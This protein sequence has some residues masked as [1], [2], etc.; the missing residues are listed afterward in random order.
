MAPSS[1]DVFHPI[2]RQWFEES[3]AAP[4]N[5][6]AR[7]W[8]RIAA[9]EH[10]LVTAPT[11]SGK[12]LTAFLWAI[13]RLLTGVWPGGCVRVLYVSPLRA[14]N[15]DI[16]R[17]LGRPLEELVERFGAAGVEVPKI[18]AMT[19]SGDTSPAERRRMLKSP[20][21]ILI[22]T[23]ESLN[24]L[25]TS[26][27]GRR[28][29][30]GIETVILDEV[31]AVAATKRGT[32]LITAVDRL[33]L[34]SGEFQRLAL[35]AT[36]RPLETIGEWIGGY[37][38]RQ[39]AGEP[40]DDAVYRKRSVRL[41]R[42]ADEKR[43][44]VRVCSTV[45]GE[46]GDD[47]ANPAPW[48]RMTEAFRKIVRTN[49]STLF[50]ANSRRLTEKVTRL[51]NEGEPAELAYSHHGS[52]SREV[53]AVVERRLKDGELQAIVATSSLE[54]G[55]DV[56]SLDEVVLIQTPRAISAAVQ[57][58]GRA[59]HGVGETSRAR[60][61]PTH[62]R[63]FL[64]AAVVARSIHAGE[65]EA[66]RP[67]TGALD[68]LAQVILSMTA[69]ETWQIDRLFDQL[70]TSV[71]YHRLSRRQFELVLEMLAGRYAD[72][73]IRELRPRLMVDRVEGTVKARRGTARLVYLAGGTIADR[74]YYALRLEESLAKIGE[75]DEEFVFERS[76]GD[77]FT[78]GAQNW[79]I[80]RITHNDVL[81]VPARR[82]SA[83]APFWRADALDR[84]AFFSEKIA[85]LLGFADERLGEDVLTETLS[86]Q[87]RLEPAAAAE[88]V[89]FLAR[90][91][92][93]T[94]FLPHRRR[95]LVERVTRP[96]ER[97]DREQLI[98]HTVWGGR[99]NRPLAI[100]LAGAWEERYGERLEIVHDDDCLLLLLPRAVAGMAAEEIFE[101]V[102]PDEIEELLRRRLEATGFFG[103]R[104]RV[105]A[106]TALLLPRSGFRHRTPLWLNRQRSKKLIE[107]VARYGDFP[108]LVETWR[109]CLE[110][111]LDLDVLRSRLREVQGG[112]VELCEVRTDTPSPFAAELGWQLVNRYMYEDDTPENLLGGAVRPDLLRELVFESR[113]RP[114]LASELVERFRQKLQRTAPGYA[115]R[116]AEELREW[117]GERMLLPDEEWRE[118]LERMAS[119]HGLRPSELLSDLAGRAVR[120]RLPGAEVDVVVVLER[121]AGVVGTVFPVADLELCALDDPSRPAPATARA[122]LEHLAANR[123]EA[124]VGEEDEGDD[125]TEE[126]ARVELLAEWLR[127][128]GP[129]ASERLAAIFG[130]GEVELHEILETLQEERRIVVDQLVRRGYERADSAV[131]VSD[132]ENLEILLRWLRREGRPSFEARRA[133]ALPLFFAHHQG[134][135]SRGDGIEDLRERLET[136]FGHPAPAA[137]WETEILPAR[138]T[139]YYSAWLDSLMQESDLLWLGVGEKRLTFALPLDLELFQEDREPETSNGEP[140]DETVTPDDETV[141]P[142]DEV[143]Q[144][145]PERR[146]RFTLPE[147]AD[148][149]GASTAELGETLWRLAWAGRVSNDTFAAVRRGIETKWQPPEPLRPPVEADRRR[150]RR[151]S[152]RRAF[153]RWKSTRPFTG[154]WLRLERETEPLDALDREELVKDRVRILLGRYGLLFRELL[155]RELGPLGW[156]RVFRTLRLMELSG[157][158]LAGHFFAGIRGLQFISKSAFRELRRGL[159]EDAIYWLNATDPASLCGVGVEGLKEALPARQVTSHLVYHGTRLVLVSRR[160]GREL[161]FNV[162]PDHPHLVDYLEVLK[163][164][165]TRDIRPLKSIHVERVNDEPVHQSPYTPALAEIFRVVKEPDGLKLWR[166]Y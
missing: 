72:S 140:D 30:G 163:V 108:I 137:V 9:G 32:H 97:E 70:R 22:T 1:L 27:G 143:G 85:A 58:V 75:L 152:G 2:V 149:T 88:L 139:P 124:P 100:A 86:S 74:G 53:R 126:D 4:T 142:D 96:D 150:S 123:V 45:A 16:R 69:A 50:F 67:V 115:P 41:V 111:E 131:E 57:R 47:P 11:G 121:L 71:P 162:G 18:T 48:E 56:G 20:P 135:V 63:D 118:L 129:V 46:T 7:A 99:V 81:V 49:R 54:L 10:V 154:R 91:K 89:D 151:R 145:F 6:Q 77:T 36:V 158:V 35:S 60:I 133:E 110:D 125:D 66:V 136:L 98:L 90:Q 68:V 59:G 122:A 87:Y 104:F 12:T 103:A 101:L 26:A 159:P 3:F 52:L 73:R 55:I 93:A 166:R 153:D 21:E 92:A 13:D 44:D 15:T 84:D 65:I 78:L 102:P 130:W 144:L 8:P 64:D 38:L 14:L 95:L 76:L 61:F 106:Q 128:T 51:V 19:R 117:L 40:G 29:L 42:S 62:G 161:L 105:A 112:E 120:T 113:L 5:V 82:S 31:H 156:S 114:L 134:L 138:L 33:V 132:A 37:E 24:I 94:G 80:R 28:I 147:L 107:T 155:S 165:L 116:D 23:P 148:H 39:P 127:L 141:T 43:Y 157:E 83:M 160:R 164:L 109:T 25:L 119:D 79:Q 34:L 17:N 146:G